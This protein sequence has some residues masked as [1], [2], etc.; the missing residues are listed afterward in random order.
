MNKRGMDY[1]VI[2]MFMRILFVMV[3]LVVIAVIIN[4][5]INLELQTQKTEA[6]LLVARIMHSPEG[7]SHVDPITGRVVT[8]V[9][10][11]KNINNTRLDNGIYILNNNRIAARVEVYINKLPS[12]E[13]FKASYYKDT[14]FIAAAKFNAQVFDGFEPIADAFS[15]IGGIGG[16]LS[17]TKQYPV[18]VLLEDGTTRLGNVQFRVLIPKS[19]K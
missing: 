16:V 7:I 17:F 5:A 6:S 9:I 11:I 4:I 13:Q 15:N 1:N 14:E 18:T 12:E 8:G 19:A 3:A 2:A 10:D